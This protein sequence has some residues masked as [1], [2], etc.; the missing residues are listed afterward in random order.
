M[1]GSLLKPR[2]QWSYITPGEIKYKEEP[3]VPVEIEWVKAGKREHLV[4]QITF[5]CREDLM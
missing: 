2:M 1:N 3:H 5:D 4:F